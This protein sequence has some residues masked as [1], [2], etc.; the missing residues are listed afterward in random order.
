MNILVKNG[1]VVDPDTKRDGKFD[2]LIK[3]DLIS[4]VSPTI[5]CKADQIID[6]DGCFVMPG[7]IDMHVH[8]RDPGLTHKETIESG[9]K[10]AVRG[11]FT[12]ICAMPNTKPVCDNAEVVEY[13]KSKADNADL[14]NILPIGAITK[15]QSGEELADI[16]EM[17][18]AGIIGISEDGKSVMNSL[19]Y[20]NAMEIAL[21]S[22]MLVLAH[23]EDI[24]LVDGGV[25]NDDSNAKRLHLK[26]ISNEVEDIIIARDILL[27]NMTGARLHICHVSTKSGVEII[28]FAKQHGLKVTAECCPHHFSLSSNDIKED[29][30]NFKMNPP[31]RTL[32]DV[33]A[34]IE[35][36]R[37]GSIDV[38]STDHAPHHT[39]E[40]AGG[41]NSA[42]FGITGLETA[43]GVT[44]TY[45]LD[46]GLITPLE[47]AQ[48]TSYNA[49]KILKIDKGSLK[50][51]KV[52]DIV[53]FDP[54]KTYTVD[55]SK[56]ASMGKNTPYDGKI[57]KGE[58]KYTIVSG[59][60]K[61]N[62][63]EE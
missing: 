52:A 57:L 27:S 15:N 24:N 51:G 9:A 54:D 36:L 56:F 26:G 29:D 1:R 17:E 42:P 19:I 11:G 32:D 53:I 38:I 18:N 6:A 10:A 48:I 3:D 60:I 62:S 14:C 16:K 58:V 59:N 23:C 28:R 34:I 50:E 55:S 61:Y 22:D 47:M 21:E 13:I 8:L 45:L 46:K 49:A 44:V 35:G 20:K 43:L 5:D 63:Y 2:I 37:D 41:F 39:D 30:A 40:K 12:T 33:N 7:F 4:E 31:L 25:M